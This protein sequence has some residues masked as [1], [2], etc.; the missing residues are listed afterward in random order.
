MKGL[1]EGKNI[2]FHTIIFAFSIIV[3][4][5][6]IKNG[7]N[8]KSFSE[9]LSVLITSVISCFFVFIISKILNLKIYQDMIMKFDGVKS[10]N[11]A[12]FG[13]YMVLSIGI[14]MEVI[15]K[16]IYDLDNDKDKSIDTPWKEE[17]KKGI[18]FG[19]KEIYEKI[20]MILF[21]FF[22]ISL[23]EISMNIN[24]SKNIGE[25]FNLPDIFKVALMA[26]ISG[27]GVIIS[28]PI[29]SAIYSSFNRK[30]TIYKTI[31]EN[32]LDGKRS[33]KL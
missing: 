26:V 29:T 11:S 1:S 5:V 17:F 19:K 28:V 7:I 31:S 6:C 10:G 32:K 27:I 25:I 9:I 12:I 33:L 24:N 13:V 20:N 2:I 22:G 8:K 30:K 18:E 21:V 3:I 4:N 23:F 14:F 15:S 16:I